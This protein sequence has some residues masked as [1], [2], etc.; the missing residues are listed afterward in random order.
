MTSDDT[1]DLTVKLIKE[2][3]YFGMEQDQ[4]IIMKQEKVPSLINNEAHFA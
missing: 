1:Y 4:L 2:N 3:N